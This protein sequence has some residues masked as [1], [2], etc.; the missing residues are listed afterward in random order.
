MQ[1]EWRI[2]DAQAG[3]TTG[4]SMM[5]GKWT[6][7]ALSYDG[8]NVIQY[9]NGQ[10]VNFV[11]LSGH[12]NISDGKFWLGRNGNEFF[13]MYFHGIIDD[14]KNFREASISFRVENSW[15]ESSG[16]GYDEIKM[17]RWTGTEW[18]R[19][20][21]N[22]KTKDATYSYYEARTYGF[23]HFAISGQKPEP[24]PAAVK[25]VSSSGSKAIP[26]SRVMF[27]PSFFIFVRAI[28]SIFGSPSIPTTSASG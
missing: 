13:H 6:L 16:L 18:S 7:V 5:S 15:I 11:P 10:K 28:S 24:Q 22:K 12:L 14:T 27:C 25:P 2:N 8:K 9:I 19:L 21:T 23:S 20:D 4:Q 3:H 17:F 26:S 1:S